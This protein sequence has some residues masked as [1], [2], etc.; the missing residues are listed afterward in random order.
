MHFV[1]ILNS[2][3]LAGNKEIY[4]TIIIRCWIINTLPFYIVDS[5]IYFNI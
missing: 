1:A 5:S 4:K 2:V 3:Y